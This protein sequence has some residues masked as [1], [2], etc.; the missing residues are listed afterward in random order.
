MVTR[1]SYEQEAVE[2]A[3]Q[4]LMEVMSALGEYRDEIVLIGGWVPSLLVNEPEER[5]VGSLDI[6]LAVNHKEIDEDKYETILKLLEDRGFRQEGQ[7]FQ[8]EKAIEGNST[9]HNVRIDLLAGQYDGTGKSRRHQNAQ[10]LKFRKARG[11]DMVFEDCVEITIEGSLPDRSIN[12]VTFKIASIAAF[13]AMKGMALSDRLKEKDAYDIYFCVKEWPGGIS[14]LA[15]EIEPSFQ[16]FALI[17]EG[18]EKISGKF[19]SL[20]HIGPR[21]VAIFNDL[22]EDDESEEFQDTVRDAFERINALLELLKT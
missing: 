4:V 18:F 15:K 5:H 11:A 9:S 20:N 2:V 13:L 10:G 1:D 22:D 7:P 16:R 8:F 14:A 6:D 3:R 17:R 19:A 21:Y 12:K